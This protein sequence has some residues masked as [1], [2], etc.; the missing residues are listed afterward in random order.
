MTR[1][2]LVLLV[3]DGWGQRK[4]KDSNA[5]AEGAPYFH[6][7]LSENPSTLLTAC[8][9]E[10]GLPLGVMGNSEVGHTNLG[11]GRVVYQDVSRIDKAIE[12][13]EFARNAAFGELMADVRAR[14]ATLHLMGLVS[15][16]MVHSSDHHLRTLLQMA[17]DQGLEP[18]RVVVHAITDGRDTPPRSGVDFVAALEDACAAAGVGRVVS[19]IGRYFA[20]DRDKRWERVE[21]AYRLFVSGEGAR[22]DSAVGAVRASYE[23]G[24]TDEFIEPVV[25][26]EPGA[27]RIA[28]GDGVLLFNYRA[29]RMREIT[30]ALV[31]VGFDGFERGDGAPS[32]QAVSMTQ[33]RDDID[34]PVA[35]PPVDLNGIFP[36]LISAA[37]LRQ[38]RIAETEKYA[39]VTYFFSGG[40]E[41]PYEGE[42]RTLIQSPRV[43]TY[44]LAPQMS[45]PEVTAAILSSLERG[46]TDV[47]VVNF[48]NADMV[49][50]TG[51]YE[52]ALK[53]VETVDGCLKQ[54]VPAVLARG[55][56]VAITAD[57][58]NSEQLWDGSTDQPHTAHTLNKVPFV[59]V[60]GGTSG[61]RMREH[62]VLADVA[63]TLLEVMGLDRHP[64]MDGQSL[65][66]G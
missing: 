2:P 6:E 26:G 56:S 1:K 19:V 59:L 50:H 10:V 65:I 23:A 55:G 9:S 27:G 20:M 34:I 42:T 39:H 49:G 58:G 38:E 44:D 51:I 12:A 32:V 24:V 64:S 21:R 14:G 33:Y 60:G 30:D 17:A 15:D 25:I 28:D 61:A 3:L 35:F 57:H 52:A 18:D 45:A 54:I 7:L 16:G 41:A 43:A 31:Q 66:L 62:G 47:Y 40:Q 37:G 13:G 29:D 8:G 53:A 36:E 4:E 22:H 46:E 5:I 63:P 11:A 48:A